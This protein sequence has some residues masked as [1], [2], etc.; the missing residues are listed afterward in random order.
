MPWP[1]V[2]LENYQPGT[3][4]RSVHMN[5]LQ[6]TVME[7]SSLQGA[8]H[9]A[10]W[11]R[12]M[13]G[14]DTLAARPVGDALSVLADDVTRTVR[15]QPGV[16]LWR[17]S[18]TF[19]LRHHLDQEIEVTV[20]RPSTGMRYDLLSYKLEVLEGDQDTTPLS[21]SQPQTTHYDP[22]NKTTLTI[23]LTSGTPDG[24][25]PQDPAPPNDEVVFTRLRINDHDGLTTGFNNLGD[26]HDLRTP[27]GHGRQ[28]LSLSTAVGDWT[29]I[30]NMQRWYGQ[31]GAKL[32]IPV[33]LA[34]QRH[35]R[36][37]ALWLLG[38]FH[39]GDTV[40]EVNADAQQVPSG[41]T[42]LGTAPNDVSAAVQGV[43]TKQ[44]VDLLPA[45]R[46]FEETELEPLWVEG[47]PTPHTHRST[48]L[49]WDLA[50][51]SIRIDI[52]AA[53]G[54]VS[55]GVPRTDHLYAVVAEWWGA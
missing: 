4:V 25:S 38:V 35:L 6:H 21:P 2:P 9:W 44:R 51:S 29:F 45:Y 40:I 23:T 22:V 33:R 7:L 5:A 17:I 14:D 41:G 8:Q 15:I 1:T 28:P 54:E 3:P 27:A 36:L 48:P 26:V 42:Q 52:T 16:L 20:E 13:F 31:S 50:E 43:G 46:T 12:S 49:D 47:R 34:N 18:D 39:A 19:V 24:T 37:R 10:L 55:P 32:Y 30:P 11:G 53:T